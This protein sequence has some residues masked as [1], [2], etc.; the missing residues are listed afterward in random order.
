MDEELELTQEWDKNKNVL[1]ISSSL[2][3]N[4]NSET[5]AKKIAEGAK[6]NNNV[7]M[8][9]IK[10]YEINYCKG[11]LACQNTGKC[12]I[13]DGV[14]DIIDKVKNAD[15]L[16]FATPIYYYSVSGQLKT[17]LDRLNPL[18]IADYKYREVYLI[19]SAADDNPLAMDGAEK[20]IQGWID[21]F[22]G[23]KLKGI[24][25]GLSCNDAGDVNKNKDL[26]QKAYEMGKNI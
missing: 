12:I 4:S 16:V 21:C 7:E 17:F 6:E 5:L 1:I 20:T 25:K 3:N 8:I 9:Y 14:K 19:T 11:C 18:Y 26:L 23:V 13:N 15:V 22:D 10:D 24:I 2:R